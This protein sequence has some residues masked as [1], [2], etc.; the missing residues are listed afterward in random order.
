DE[1]IAKVY[2][3]IRIAAEAKAPKLIHTWIT[4]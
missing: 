1:V 4:E 2:D 3:N